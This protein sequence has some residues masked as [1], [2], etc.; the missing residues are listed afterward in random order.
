MI[1]LKFVLFY[2]GSKMSYLRYLCFKTLRHFHPNASIKMFTTE[3]NTSTGHCWGSERQDFENNIEGKDYKE[4][5]KDLDVEIVVLK[6]FA[7]Q[8]NP[9]VQSDMFR[10]WYLKNNGGF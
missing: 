3:E 9:V 2:A 4:Y 10:Y 8:Y 6:N 1:D 7:V 5:L